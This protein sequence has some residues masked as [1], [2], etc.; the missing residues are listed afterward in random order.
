[1]AS[2]RESRPALPRCEVGSKRKHRV[3]QAMEDYKEN[4]GPAG[5]LRPKRARLEQPV[6]VKLIYT[7]FH[8]TCT[9]E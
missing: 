7:I 3:N 9:I 2:F 8:S 4:L 5:N 1:M 6:K